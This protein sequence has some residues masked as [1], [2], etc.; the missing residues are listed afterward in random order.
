MIAT[1]VLEC[2]WLRLP[3]TQLAIVAHIGEMEDRIDR[4]QDAASETTTLRV[5][6]TLQ[7]SN[8][9]VHG[10]MRYLIRDGLVE[11]GEVVRVRF[12]YSGPVNRLTA[13]GREMYQSIRRCSR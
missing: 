13:E 3:P 2:E 10:A 5:R 7:L 4:G 12:R 1:E 8:S 6:E 11:R 9:A